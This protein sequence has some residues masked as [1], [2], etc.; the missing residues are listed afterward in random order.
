MEA[1][2]PRS[3]RTIKALAIESTFGKHEVAVLGR[4]RPPKA[5]GV[6]YYTRL[7]D[8]LNEVVSRLSLQ[9]QFVVITGDLNPNRLRPDQPEGK[10]L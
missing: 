2:V 6:N 4:Y 5:S 7:E 9:K 10:I 3:Y 8:K 1:P